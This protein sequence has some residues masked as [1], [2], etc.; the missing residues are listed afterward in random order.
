M[1]HYINYLMVSN[2]QGN[3]S[4][5]DQMNIIMTDAHF[6]LGYQ[7]KSRKIVVHRTGVTLCMYYH[8]YILV[9]QC[10]FLN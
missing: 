8:V 9:F 10:F 7:A 4:T 6:V 2:H 5:P 3:F 1:A